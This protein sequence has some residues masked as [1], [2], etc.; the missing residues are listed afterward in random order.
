M[1]EICKT[2]PGRS[3]GNLVWSI[4]V[5]LRRHDDAGT[6]DAVLQ[7]DALLPTG[8]SGPGLLQNHAVDARPIRAALDGLC[9]LFAP[10]ADSVAS[11]S[12]VN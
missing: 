12:R 3:R 10:R 11:V 2:N 7:F 9:W 8:A 5:R 6:S 4:C 1:N